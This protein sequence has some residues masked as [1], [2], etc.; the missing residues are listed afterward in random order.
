MNTWKI[1][2]A[3]VLGASALM[4]ASACQPKPSAPRLV[5]LYATCTVNK[6]FLSPYNPEIRFTPN[7]EAFARDA[8]VFTNHVTEAGQ[9]GIAYASIFSGVHADIHGV[10]RHPFRLGGHV[11]QI[12]EAY[13][14]AGYETFFWSGHQLASYAL[15]YGQGVRNSNAYRGSKHRGQTAYLE[16]RNLRNLTATNQQFVNILKQLEQDPE[17]KAFVQINFT[18]TH[19]AYHENTSEEVQRRFLEAFP[20]ERPPVGDENFARLLA[21]YDANN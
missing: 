17:Y 11:Y 2:I 1:H 16:S 13:R 21:I 7:L 12:S 3:I 6:D 9:S 15:N 18:I 8:V 20:D 4:I 14:D 5:I 10:Y 19:P